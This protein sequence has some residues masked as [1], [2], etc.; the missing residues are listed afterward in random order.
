M[1]T[2]DIFPLSINGVQP[3]LNLL[4]SLIPV[5]TTSKYLNY[6]IDLGSNPT[7]C[8][9]IQFTAF[10]YEVAK[11]A[12]LGQQ[13]L[14][15]LSNN[16]AALQEATSAF[17][18]QVSTIPT[19][20]QTPFATT[21]GAA[22]GAGSQFFGSLGKIINTNG[23]DLAN[24]T[25][26]YSLAKNYDIN[27]NQNSPESIISLYM[28]DSLNTS[29]DS[30]YTAISMTDTLG[31]GGYISNAMSD[32]S[33]EDLVNKDMA[34]NLKNPALRAGLTK[35]G[36][37]LA[38][39][40]VQAAGGDSGNFQSVLERAF[41]MYPNPQMQ[42]VYKGI[43]LREFQFEFIFTP[44]SSQEAVMVDTII[45]RFV[46]HSVPQLTPGTNGQYLI[47]PQI[48]QIKFAYTNNPGLVGAVSNVFQNTLSNIFGS[49]LSGGLGGNPLNSGPNGQATT[50]SISGAKLF[51]IGDCVLTNVSVD[52][53][54]NG[55]AAY[56]DGHPIQTRMTLQF[57]EMDIVTK[58]KI[59]P[60]TQMA[61]NLGG[62]I[63]NPSGMVNNSISSLG[64]ASSYG[65]GGSS[66]SLYKNAFGVQ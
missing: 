24:Q 66:E 42:M 33:Y 51:N 55:W 8:H 20:G 4:A 17:Y 21:A 28:P 16:G 52:Y 27:V 62:D 13:T 5:N 54:P 30:N 12:A 9:A 3:P 6:P 50:S 45:K 37:Y 26:Q 63:P 36:I 46:Y 57:K 15:S 40:G 47:P 31:L 39:Q 32:L 44:V 10:D 19:G 60:T 53:A 49:Q 1:A 61:P 64:N 59:I 34:T 2:I 35:L 65:T 29:Y 48:F 43:N 25:K 23:P 41:K 58:D 56:T 18:N 14:T 11:L 22:A 38:G 7:Y